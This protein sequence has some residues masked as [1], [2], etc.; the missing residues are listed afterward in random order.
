LVF[1]SVTWAVSAGL[2]HYGI[3]RARLNLAV[4]FAVNNIDTWQDLSDDQARKLITSEAERQWAAKRDLGV[5]VHDLIERAIK[6]EP[7]AEWDR[8][9]APYLRGAKSFIAD[10]DFRFELLEATVFSEP[11]RY[12]G[13]FDFIGRSER[14]PELGLCLGD[15]KT[16]R[17]GVWPE[18]ALQLAAY[19]HADYVLDDTDL[20]LK[21]PKADRGLL[22]HLDGEDSYSVTE[23]DISVATW[24]TFLS[25]LEVARSLRLRAQSWSAGS[26]RTSRRTSGTSRISS[27]GSVR[28]RASSSWRCLRSSSTRASRP[29]RASGRSFTPNGSSPS[30]AKPRASRKDGQHDKSM[31]QVRASDAGW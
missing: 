18:H 13:T 28:C 27:S 2:P 12:A 31:G 5:T 11:N 19:R 4:D 30:C 3:T 20:I 22:V 6:R 8:S 9:L 15:W 17:S 25:V 7:V 29:G 26:T 23:A 1:D 24:G 16:G 10:F 14:F 21:L